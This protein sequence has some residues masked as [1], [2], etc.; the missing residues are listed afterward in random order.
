MRSR[1]YV[2]SGMT[3]VGMEGKMVQFLARDG[4]EYQEMLSEDPSTIHDII[5]AVDVFAA[6]LAEF[7]GGVAG[8]KLKRRSCPDSPQPT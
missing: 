1:I 3:C 8:G 6:L 7:R 2:S 4:K 5:T